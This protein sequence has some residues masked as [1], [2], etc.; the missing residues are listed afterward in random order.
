[1]GPDDFSGHRT[2]RTGSMIARS[3]SFR[4]LAIHPLV[5]GTLDQVLGDHATSY[6]LH[7]TQVIDIG[8]GEPGQLVHRD[9]WAFDFFPFPSGYEV[10][11]HVMWAMTDFTELNGATRVIPGS[12]KWEDKLRPQYEETVPAEMPKGSVFFYVGSVYHGGGANQSDERR[13]GINVG[14]TLSWL[15]QEENQY[16]ACPPDVARTIDEDLAKL[17]GYRRGAYALGYFG[18]LQ[19]PMEA[20]HGPRDRGFNT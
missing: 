12:H 2:R 1:M 14:Y 3:P 15:R 7:L 16:L 17:I 20:V 6:Q 18:D 11:C 19:D 5:T 9:Q 8:P 13:L 4:P 10:E